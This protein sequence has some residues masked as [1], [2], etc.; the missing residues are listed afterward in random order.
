[1]D[2][3]IEEMARKIL[4]WRQVAGHGIHNHDLRRWAEHLQTVVQPKLDE[5]EK[6]KADI[7]RVATQ[8]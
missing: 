1:M 5:L 7:S 4:N 6:L 3:I 8:K 2:S